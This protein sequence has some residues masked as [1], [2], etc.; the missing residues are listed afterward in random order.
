MTEDT[1]TAAKS[2]VYSTD[3]GTEFEEPSR[4]VTAGDNFT[5]CQKM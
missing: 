3:L 2:T 4:A 1:P 5:Q